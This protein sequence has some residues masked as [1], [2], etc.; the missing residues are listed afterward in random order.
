MCCHG[1]L[2]LVVKT[3]GLACSYNIL[4]T[5]RKKL[6][7]FTEGL[8]RE[9]V[10]QNRTPNWGIKKEYLSFKNTTLNTTDI[11]FT[12]HFPEMLFIGFAYLVYSVILNQDSREG[13]LVLLQAPPTLQKK[14]SSPSQNINFKSS[15]F[16][17]LS[18]QEGPPDWPTHTAIALWRC[19]WHSRW[20]WPICRKPHAPWPIIYSLPTV[21]Y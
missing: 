16:P 8:L 20:S 10:I 2:F 6:R 21:F 14:R 7:W 4:V 18:Y 13:M 12:K 1:T 9:Q 17:F 5:E 11:S 19:P 15:F 3:D